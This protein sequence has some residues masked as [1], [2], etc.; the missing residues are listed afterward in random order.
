MTDIGEIIAP[1]IGHETPN[2]K[3]PFCPPKARKGYT[4]YS[5]V[6]NDSERLHEIMEDPSCLPKKQSGARPQVDDSEIEQPTPKPRK[7]PVGKPYTFQAHHLISGKQALAGEPIEQWIKAEKSEKP[8]GYSVNNTNNG[9]WAPSIPE[10]YKTK[11]DKEDKKEED[12][13]ENKKWSAL[14]INDRQTFAE[15]VMDDA[16]AQI[17]IG[18]HHI[19]DPDNPEGTHY[20]CYDSYIKNKLKELNDRVNTWAEMCNCKSDKNKKKQATHHLH[21]NIDRLSDH[22]QNLIKGTPHHWTVFLSKYALAYHK[23]NIDDS[24][25]RRKKE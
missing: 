15:E 17:H 4:T 7:K 3:C 14:D 25:H 13:E 24:N 2:D 20:V 8:T 1:A 12:N 10:K 16:N 9:F 23:K 22:M 6:D 11:R 21:N 5:G 18:H 19:E